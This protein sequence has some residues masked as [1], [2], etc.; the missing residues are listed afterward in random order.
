MRCES[1]FEERGA[2]GPCIATGKLNALSLPQVE[3]VMKTE[4]HILIDPLFEVNPIRFV[5]SAKYRAAIYA[6]RG[7]RAVHWSLL[8][9]AAF[10]A[11][12]AFLAA[13][14]VAQITSR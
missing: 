14:L 3:K 7:R 1:R 4:I 2:D 8:Y 12:A 11:L 10:T 13:V 6:E 5:C 9:W